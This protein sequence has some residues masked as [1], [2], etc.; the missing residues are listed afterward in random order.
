MVSLATLIPA[1]AGALTI[2]APIAY[3]LNLVWPTWG[4]VAP[5]VVWALGAVLAAWPRERIQRVWYGYRD[6]TTEE[7][8]RLR[9]PARRALHRTAV[10]AGR[11]RLMIVKSQ[12]LNAPAATGRTVVITSYAASSLPPDRLEAVLAHELIHHIGLHAVPVFCHA[13]LMLPIRALWWLL[14]RIWRPVRRTWRVAVAWHTPFGFLVAFLLAIV[15]VAVIV[16]SVIPVCV[17]FLGAALSR[18]STD[19]AE[20]HADTAVAGFGL[21]PQLLA[22]LETA[23]EAGHIGADR[24]GHFLALP[25]LAVRRAQRLRKK[26][27]H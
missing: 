13:Q 22:A 3:G 16:I 27:A 4:A 19:Q 1:A 18:I 8:R 24:A 14:V 15:A 11:V 23:I 7:L 9:E 5:F 21:G 17:A 10:S 12:E 20:F 2:V 6:P 25:P 26:L